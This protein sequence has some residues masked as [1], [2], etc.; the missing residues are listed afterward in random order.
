LEHAFGRRQRWEKAKVEKAK[1]EKAKEKAKGRRQRRR[2]RGEGKGEGK[3]EKAKVSGCAG[4]SR[5]RVANERVAR[6][7]T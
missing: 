5:R 3:G 4:T 2:Q 7:K 6:G 1:V